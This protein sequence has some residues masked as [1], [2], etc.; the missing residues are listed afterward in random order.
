M[1]IKE[2]K[3]KLFGNDIVFGLRSPLG[4]VDESNGRVNKLKPCIDMSTSSGGYSKRLKRVIHKKPKPIMLVVGEDVCLHDIVLT[5]KRILVGC[6]SGR[7][8]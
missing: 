4:L 5:N 3:K 1:N 8:E 2:D 7:N 6:F